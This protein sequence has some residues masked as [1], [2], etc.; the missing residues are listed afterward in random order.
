M[1]IL[2]K[3][4]KDEF[5]I[6][7]VKIENIVMDSRDIIKNSLFFAIN[8]GNSYIDKALEMGAS[9][10][11][12]DNYEKE[13]LRVIK[14]KNTI[15]TMQKIANLYRKKLNLKVIGITGSNGKTTTKDILYSLLSTKYKCKKTLGNYNNHI[16][17]PFTILGCQDEDEV[18][19]LEMGMSSFGEIDK[20]CR[21]SEPNYGIVTNIG[22][23][24]LEFLKTR[25]NVAIAK[26]ELAKYIDQNHLILFGDDFYLKDKSGIKV[27]TDKSN[28]FQIE[29]I[30]IMENATKF[31]L[32]K[33]SYEISL[34]GI[35]NVYNAAIGI[36]IAKLFGLKYEEIKVGLNNIKIT[37]GRFEK[38][39]V[40]DNIYINDAYNASPISTK[41]ALETFG[42]LYNDRVKI[43]CLGDM[44]ELGEN[45][46]NFHAE[47]I[48]KAKD[49]NF[50]KIF[51][52]GDRMKKALE[53]LGK[54]E[55]VTHFQ[56]KEEIKDKITEIK[57]KKAILLKGS[58]GMKMEEI[59]DRETER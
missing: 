28:D 3:I 50:D 33:E 12:A 14:V 56:N 17:V 58:R 45:E 16:G 51:L 32:N 42:N 23:S 36:A 31:D 25:A 1:N 24:H 22:D 18:L 37:S 2:S 4:L 43:V 10:V 19:V 41:Y 39:E 9:L 7:N 6:E 11:I 59:L 29:N 5:N 15:E 52:Y 27:G 48:K 38:I 8:N 35:H 40:E 57:E 47:T 53:G 21:I 26:L 46:I 30:Q 54:F 49:I 20:L 55:N 13:D 44:L 34:N